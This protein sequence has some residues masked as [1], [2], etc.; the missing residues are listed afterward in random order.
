M[1]DPLIPA[2]QQLLLLESGGGEPRQMGRRVRDRRRPQ[3]H[4]GRDARVVGA[5]AA[6]QLGLDDH[7]G[8]VGALD[9]VLG[10]VLSDRTPAE[11]DD[12]GGDLGS[13]GGRGR[14]IGSHVRTLRRC[15]RA[16]TGPTH[17]PTAP[18]AAS[19]LP[20]VPA[21]VSTI[22]FHP[23]RLP[24]VAALHS[25]SA[26]VSSRALHV[27]SLWALWITHVCGGKNVRE[28]R[29]LTSSG[30]SRGELHEVI[31]NLRRNCRMSDPL[32]S[33]EV[34]DRRKDPPLTITDDRGRTAHPRGG[35]GR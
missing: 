33:L 21:A 31:H 32:D 22:A 6:E 19:L 27:P 26:I 11:H 4:L 25:A 18:S 8:E 20:A 15:G 10:E 16:V 12:V 14:G 13:R 1:R 9:R 17:T 23:C 24:S 2:R 28:N 34:L 35:G 5:L 30:R 7:S 29:L 3:Q